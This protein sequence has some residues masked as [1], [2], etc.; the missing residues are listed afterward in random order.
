MIQA[1]CINPVQAH[2]AML[3]LVWPWVKANTAATVQPAAKTRHRA[4]KREISKNILKKI[5]EHDGQFELFEGL[6]Q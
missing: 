6:T 3:S 1:L 4:A 5:F 2:N